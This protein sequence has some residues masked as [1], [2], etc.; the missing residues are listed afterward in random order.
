MQI[1]ARTDG[2]L[3]AKFLLLADQ[4]NLTYTV[5]GIAATLAQQQACGTG[6]TVTAF[7]SQATQGAATFHIDAIEHGMNQ[8]PD[9]TFAPFDIAGTVNGT[10]KKT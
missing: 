10:C 7:T 1:T 8:Q 3:T 9:G 4:C 6:F 5:S 2:T